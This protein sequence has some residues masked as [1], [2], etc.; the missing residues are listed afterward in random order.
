MITT[1]HITS[2]GDQPYFHKS[3][4]G[5]PFDKIIY[6]PTTEMAE[7][8]CALCGCVLCTGM[9]CPMC[10][11]MQWYVV[12]YVLCYVV[13][14]VLCYVVVCCAL[15]VVLCNVKLCPMY[16]MQ[17]YVVPYVV[18]CYVVVCCALCGCIRI[19]IHKWQRVLS[20]DTCMLNSLN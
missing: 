11:A 19:H 10:Y 8:C 5:K 15:C 4:S 3:P 6:R 1:Q 2:S 20:A 7:V 18:V 14:Y 17:Q 12:P 13:P 9:L 16:A